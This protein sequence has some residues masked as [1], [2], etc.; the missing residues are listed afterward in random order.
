MEKKKPTFALAL[1]LLLM[2]AAIMFINL[3]YYK[4]VSVASSLIVIIVLICI[5][6]KFCLAYNFNEMLEI[7]ADSIKNGSFGLMFFIAIGAIIAAWMIS[8]TIPAIIYVGLGIISPRVFLPAGLILCSITALATGSSWATIGTVGVALIG[9]GQGMGIPIEI[10]A[11]MILSGATFGDKISPISDIPNLTA[12]STGSQVYDVIKAMLITITP[13]YL[14][15]FILFTLLGFKFSAT[16][17]NYEII[18]ET[19][20]I[21]AANFNLN[22]LVILPVLVLGILS[23]K[24][25]PALPSMAIA[26]AL[27]LLIALVFQNKDLATCIES[28]NSGFHIQ[29]NSKYVDPILNRGG[30]ESMLSTFAI[31][32][33]ALIMGGLL[34]KCGY[35]KPIVNTLLNKVKTVTGLSAVVLFTSFLSTAVLSEVYLSIILNG[36]LYKEEF[37]QRGLDR[38]MLARLISE[39]S[40]M[41]APLLPWTTFGAFCFASFGISGLKIAPYAFLNYLSPLI[42]LLMTSFGI[43]IMW[44]NAKIKL[45]KVGS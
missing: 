27:A 1:S 30:L 18:N 20:N 42:S 43:G 14:I 16:A 41:P 34:D 10:T 37:K 24:K 22:P 39:A 2:I 35:L 38:S 36:S 4:T 8:G 44:E 45:E 32:F 33:L 5:V 40:F 31:A 28:L 3:M 29:T 7:M 13:A 11:A 25:F 26:V 17:M 6:S 23:Y 19:R 9:I 15:S 21:I 12:L